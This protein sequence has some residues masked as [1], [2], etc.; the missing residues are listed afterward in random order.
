[1]SFLK[2]FE[3]LS[4]IWNQLQCPQN[5][6][7]HPLGTKRVFL[8]IWAFWISP[9]KALEL[10]ASSLKNFGEKLVKFVINFN[11]YRM[12]GNALS[13][14]RGC[15]SKYWAYFKSL[16]EALGSTKSIISKEFWKRNKCN[17]EPTSM[18][19]KMF[20]K[21]LWPSRGCT[22]KFWAVF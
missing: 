20:E 10:W 6:R 13:A 18:C 5:V 21:Y 17:L 15:F 14:P 3:T 16:E 7:K 12:L 8:N 4:R 22:S 1:M 2:N 9:K 19:P 11:V